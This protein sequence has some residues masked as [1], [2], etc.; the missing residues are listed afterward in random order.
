MRACFVHASAASA[1]PHGWNSFISARACASPAADWR[2]A[3]ANSRTGTYRYRPGARAQYCYN[4]T[5]LFQT[6]VL[7]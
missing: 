7:A 5:Q 6:R 1:S 4:S 2:Y 3:C